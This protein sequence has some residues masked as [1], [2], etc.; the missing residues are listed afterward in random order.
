[1]KLNHLFKIVP[2]KINIINFFRVDNCI[3]LFSNKFQKIL[4]LRKH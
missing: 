1:M 4:K 3:I 2:Q